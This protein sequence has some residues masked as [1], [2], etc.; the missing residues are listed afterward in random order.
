LTFPSISVNGSLGA[1]LD[2]AK[3]CTALSAGACATSEV[4]FA[5]GTRRIYVAWGK[6]LPA[7]TAVRVEWLLNGRIRTEAGDQCVVSEAGCN[8]Y[9]TRTSAMLSY[10]TPIPA[11]AW[12]YRIYAAD[13]AIAQGN[14]TVR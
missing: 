5:R 2:G 8:A 14:V 3:T 11:G 9:V 10:I 7:G 6:P 1:L 13:L 12:T 4:S